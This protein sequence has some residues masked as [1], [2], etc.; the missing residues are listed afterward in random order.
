MIKVIAT[1]FEELIELHEFLDPIQNEDQLSLELADVDV[2]EANNRIMNCRAYLQLNAQ[3][4]PYPIGNGM[5]DKTELDV[6][7]N[8][9]LNYV[10]A[11]PKKYITVLK[12]ILGSKE[13][14]TGVFE[15]HPIFQP[16][17]LIWNGY[18]PNSNNHEFIRADSNPSELFQLD[19]TNKF[20]PATPAERDRFVKNYREKILIKHS[21]TENH[22]KYRDGVD[23][24]E[25]V[26]PFQTIYTVMEENN[27]TIFGLSNCIQKIIHQEINPVKHAI[28]I[29]SPDN[30]PHTP[31]PFTGKYANRSHLCP[32]C[33]AATFGYDLA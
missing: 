30:H 31:G 33:N 19:A 3:P 25:V 18:Y 21:D 9:I 12:I 11:T 1:P 20:I 28:L 26:F 10:P 7:F 15:I 27:S 5:I 4:I 8:L 14:S 17:V 29:S 13:V 16:M 22:E 2:A 32:P 23:V 6:L 24:K